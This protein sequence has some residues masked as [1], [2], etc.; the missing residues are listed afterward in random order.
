MRVNR[1]REMARK[2]SLVTRIAI[3]VSVMVAVLLGL[4]MLTIS[5]RLNT[6]IR[7]LVRE[8]NIQIAQARAAELGK[9]LDAFYWQLKVL[10]AQDIVIKGEKSVVED[11]ALKSMKS[12][13]SSEIN[14]ILI[15]WPDGK[16]KTPAGNYVDVSGRGYFKA[17]FAEG[18]DYAIGDVAISKAVNEPTVIL[19]KAIKTN[20]GKLR[21]GIAF[22]IKMETLSSIASAIKLGKTGYGWVVDQKGLVIAHP[23]KEAILALDATNADKDGYKGLDALGKRMLS[24]ESGDGTYSKKDGTK[25]VT[26]FARVSNSPGWALGLSVTESELDSTVTGLFSLL[27]VIL[28]IGIAVSVLTSIFVARS[29][30][31]PVRFVSEAL[32]IMA[33]GD[34]AGREVNEKYGLEYGFMIARRGDEIGDAA[35]AMAR[36]IERLTDVIG[37]IKVSSTEVSSGSDQLSSTAQGLSQGANEQAASIEELSA[38][39]EELASTIRQNA[40]NTKQADALSRKVAQNAEESGKSVGETVSSMKEIASKIS[41][42]EEI[43]SQTNMLALNA[44]I[45]AARAGDAGKGFA[46][47]ASEV[48][49]LA[50]RSA[51]AAGEINELSKKSVTV[52][53]DAGKRLEELV[54]DIR[55]T[56]ELIQEISAASGEQASGADQI[57]KGVTQMDMV[58]QQNASSSE[59]MAAT[60]EELAGQATSLSEAIGFFKTGEGQVGGAGTTGATAGGPAKPAEKARAKAGVAVKEGARAIAAP[61]KMAAGSKP[62]VSRPTGIAPAKDAKDSDFEEF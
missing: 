39:V 28:G 42:I 61:A 34:L 38:S 44:A 43:A 8:E 26:F 35:G 2:N 13:V 9:F 1:R 21:A 27:L 45:E 50:E 3:I 5:V 54:P 37:Q 12:V 52:A 41:I 29:I 30:A 16:A 31:K 23:T 58:V 53:G 20:E 36:L 32:T 10:S 24:S 4:S 40:D 59:E 49:K 14:T 15:M 22:E 11:Y 17:I 56:A 6:D 46:V 48:K 55:K 19:A 60:A 62:P 18:K 33:S 57:A 7:S 51:K 47:V 25:M